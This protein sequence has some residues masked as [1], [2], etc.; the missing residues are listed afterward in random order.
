ML[1]C[2]ITS[3]VFIVFIFNSLALD[4][5]MDCQSYNTLWSVQS[6]HRPC[7]AKIRLSLRTCSM[8]KTKKVPYDWSRLK[9]NT[10]VKSRYTID[11][12]HRFHAWENDE[13]ANSANT[14]YNNVIQAHREATELHVLHESR[15]CH[16]TMGRQE[17]GREERR[18][19]RC[20]QRQQCRGTS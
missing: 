13:D 1:L 5:V 2:L 14:I 4:S 10:E 9:T 12:K 15:R 19:T 7:T 17:S 20:S 18:L 8:P 3:Y 6:D 16:V 11:V